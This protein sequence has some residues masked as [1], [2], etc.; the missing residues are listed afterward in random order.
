M[1]QQP[2]QRIKTDAKPAVI[3]NPHAKRKSVSDFP[4]LVQV[5]YE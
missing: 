3:I 1:K 2:L 4:M 5:R